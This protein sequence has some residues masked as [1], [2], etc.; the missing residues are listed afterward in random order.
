MVYSPRWSV[1]HVVRRRQLVVAVV[2]DIPVAYSPRWSVVHVVRRRQL[3][4]AVV[5]GEQV[6]GPAGSGRFPAHCALQKAPFELVWT[7]DLDKL[8]AR[9]PPLLPAEVEGRE[10]LS[11][12]SSWRGV[13]DSAGAR[14]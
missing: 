13:S 3:V 10:R 9:F 7:L 5:N 6:V 11:A 1:V 2:Y 4:V 12:G 14:C 8:P